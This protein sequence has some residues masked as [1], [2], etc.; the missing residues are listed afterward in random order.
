MILSKG[1]RFTIGLAEE[2]PL[3]IFLRYAA[4]DCSE[5]FF[6]LIKMCDTRYVQAYRGGAPRKA[7]KHA[8]MSKQRCVHIRLSLP[9]LDAMISYPPPSHLHIYC[10][11]VCVCIY[12]YIYMQMCVCVYQHMS[13]YVSIRF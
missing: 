2:A 13:A 7:V 10:V 12:I 11:C 6:E 5:F 3:T 1:L 9:S 8:A 4:N